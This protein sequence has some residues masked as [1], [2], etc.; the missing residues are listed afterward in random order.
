MFL[1]PRTTIQTSF[2]CKH[3]TR[4]HIL[5]TPNTSLTTTFNV[6]NHG[7]EYVG[8]RVNYVRNLVIILLLI[9]LGKVSPL[10]IP[11]LVHLL[12]GFSS[13]QLSFLQELEVQESDVSDPVETLHPQYRQWAIYSFDSESPT[14]WFLFIFS[15]SLKQVRGK[16]LL[17][18]FCYS[19][20]ITI[21]CLKVLTS[22]NF[23]V[24]KQ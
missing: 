20:K 9:T 6:C 4:T 14:R 16:I 19:R 3:R 23:V 21:R 1:P 24:S 17:E 12:R 5:Q 11:R 7:T 18:S 15:L 22:P 13:V 8:T 10:L 2:T